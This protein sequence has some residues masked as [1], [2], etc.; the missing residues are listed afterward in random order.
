[1]K[2]ELKKEQT[3]LRIKEAALSLFSEQGY[4]TTTIEQIAK[5][6]GVAKGTF[7]NYFVSKD[8]LVCELQGVFVM[9]EIM[10]L[11]DK[12]GPLIPR[13]Q[14]VVFLLAKQLP[15]NKSM[16][17]A[18]FQAIFGSGPALDA[19]NRMKSEMTDVLVPLIK[20]GQESGELRKDMPAEMIAQLALQTYFGA[21]IVW[22]MEDKEE[23]IMD[24]LAL[25]FDLFFKGIVVKQHD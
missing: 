8:K 21:L 4:E 10:N 12:P 17:R 1:M 23:P 25:T 3:R 14:M 11:K 22:S 24:Q 2:R 7:F 20:Q 9:N 13:V 6:S 15:L 16:T 5:A 18:L 19:H